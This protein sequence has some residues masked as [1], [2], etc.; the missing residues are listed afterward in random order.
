MN[1]MILEPVVPNHAQTKVL[2]EILHKREH[3]ISHKDMPSYDKHTFFVFNNPYRC[4]FIVYYESAILGSMYVQYDNSVGLSFCKPIERKALEL[5][6]EMLRV[7][8]KPLEAIASVR[9]KDFFFN[10]SNSDV[11]L[12]NCLENIGYIRSQVSFI[13]PEQAIKYSQ[14]I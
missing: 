11:K 1:S 6:T 4:W 3:T 14:Q 9:Y 10:V 12:Q 5:L 8:V 13:Q 7:E 2:Y